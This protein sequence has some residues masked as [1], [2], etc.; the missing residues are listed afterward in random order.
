PRRARQ[1]AGPAS[2]PRPRGERFVNIP[3]SPRSG[4]GSQYGPAVAANP[5]TRLKGDAIMR[6]TTLIAT[7]LVSGG[8]I[9]A[10]ASVL[11][12]FAQSSAATT[13]TQAGWMSL[14]EVQAKLE[15]G[16][17]RDFEK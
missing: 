9:A 5:P 2:A 17:Y 1:S 11:P 4:G 14:Q 16:G 15:A 10:G 3:F 13:T 12:A 7:L 6:A 8:I